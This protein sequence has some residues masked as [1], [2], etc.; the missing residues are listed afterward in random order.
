MRLLSVFFLP[1]LLVLPSMSSVT[2]AEKRPLSLE[3]LSLLK[4]ISS[5]QISP[6]GKWVAAVVS[7]TDF[8]TESG[9]AT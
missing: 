8:E 4:S 7:V 9:K 3:D 2:A 6:D 1:I 5:P